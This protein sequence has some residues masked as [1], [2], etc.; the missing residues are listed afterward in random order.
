MRLYVNSAIVS[1]IE[2]EQS[3]LLKIV[4]EYISGV[5]NQIFIEFPSG[6]LP[7]KESLYFLKKGNNS[8]IIF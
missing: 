8:L 1:E 4:D 3:K 7:F 2:I 6:F 5:S